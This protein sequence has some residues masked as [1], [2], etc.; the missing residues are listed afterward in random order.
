MSTV[1]RGRTAARAEA[2]FASDAQ[3]TLTLE[4]EQVAEAIKS[5]LYRLHGVRGCAE[6]VAAEF[7][8]HPETAAL[9]MQWALETVERVYGAAPAEQMG[10]TSP[11]APPVWRHPIHALRARV[12]F[13][14][15]QL[16]TLSDDY[17]EAHGIAFTVLPWGTRR[18]SHPDVDAVLAARPAYQP[19]RRWAR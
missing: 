16:R 13:A 14:A 19:V 5:T 3:P 6:T 2:L 17:A 7:G 8:E 12:E 18:Y 11:P 9:R 10:E 15:E 1:R 4:P